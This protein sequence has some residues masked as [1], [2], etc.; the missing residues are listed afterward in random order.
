MAAV[1]PA[2][3]PG[4]FDSF[5]AH[6]R[7]FI[8]LMGCAEAKEP[9]TE[10]TLKKEFYAVMGTGIISCVLLLIGLI[11]QL[12]LFPMGG[13]AG[14]TLT[15]IGGGGLLITAYA[16]Y[17]HWKKVKTF[18]TAEVERLAQAASSQPGLAGQAAQ[19]VA[20]FFSN[21]FAGFRNIWPF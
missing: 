4:W 8:E 15:F 17:R 10:E 14:S 5:K 12:G 20:G 11:G 18:E 1:P 6:G 16:A 21:R 3:S 13:S 19:Q 2:T 9:V 7:T